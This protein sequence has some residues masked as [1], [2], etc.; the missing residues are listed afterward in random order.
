MIY[1]KV[2][3]D[4]SET[5]VYNCS[6]MPVYILDQ[7]LSDY[8]DRKGLCHWHKDIE[9]IYVA[10]G[11]MNYHINGKTILLR[12]RS[13]TI[14]NSQYM[15]YGSSSYYHNCQFICIRF[16]PGI[17]NSIPSVYKKYV[18]PLIEN[19]KI[20]YLSYEIDSPN[21][22]KIEDAVGQICCIRKGMEDGYELRL[23]SAIYLLWKI[24]FEECGPNLQEGPMLEPGDQTLQKRMVSY[25]YEHYQ[26]ALTLD[27]ISASANISRSKCCMI[28]KQY[29]HQS[30]VDFLNKYRLE[31]SRRLIVNTQYKI[32][33]IA[34]SCGFNHLSYFSKIFY[35]EYGCTPTEY[36]KKNQK[37]EDIS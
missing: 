19:R 5:P 17:L 18:V 4:A 29:L 10:K 11:E 23:V 20:E 36:R 21:H 34:F 2:M 25:I 6:D 14:I 28:F 15:H 9:I 37:C 1:M 7:N 16:H 32:T 8:P 27:E 13:C 12:E 33:Q 24:L 3:Q 22:H 30:P 35:N 26:D 31:V